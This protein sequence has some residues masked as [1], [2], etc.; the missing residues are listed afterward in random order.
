MRSRKKVNLKLNSNV[1]SEGIL[2]KN[3]NKSQPG[4]CRHCLKVISHMHE[5]RHAEM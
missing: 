4:D 2:I 5:V 1:F 3:M